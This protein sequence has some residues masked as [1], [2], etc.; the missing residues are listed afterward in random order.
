MSSHCPECGAVLD[1]P[2]SKRSYQQLK[3]VHALCQAAYDHWPERLRQTFNPR[4]KEHLRSWLELQAGH[5]TVVRTI[6]LRNVDPDYIEVIMTAVLRSCEDDKLFVGIDGQLLVVKRVGSIAYASLSHADA[7][8][9]FT[10][11]DAVLHT[12]DIDGQQLLKESERAA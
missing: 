9:L 7:C 4:S 1:R 8:R 3:R 12:L 2:A 10:E 6:E 11:L 5:F